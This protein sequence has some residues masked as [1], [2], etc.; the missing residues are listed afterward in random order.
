MLIYANESHWDITYCC[1]YFCIYFPSLPDNS[2]VLLQILFYSMPALHYIT[3]HPKHNRRNIHCKNG[4]SVHKGQSLRQLT[5]HKNLPS[6][7]NFLF[8]ISE[9]LSMTQFL[10]SIYILYR[11]CHKRVTAFQGNFHRILLHCIS[12]CVRPLVDL[13]KGTVASSRC[14]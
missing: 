12:V 13:P 10:P 2:C 5:N 14:R 6:K 4:K 7:I 11:G 8:Q 9:G 3:Y 1:I